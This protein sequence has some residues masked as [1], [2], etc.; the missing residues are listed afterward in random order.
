MFSS[1]DFAPPRLAAV[2]PMR[3]FV[4][5][6]AAV[7]AAGLVWVL[8]AN[9]LLWDALNRAL[10]SPADGRVVV[11]GIDDA[12]LRDYGRI[13]SWPRDLYRQALD[14]LDQAGAS[15]IGVDVLLADPAR[16]DAALA[17]VFSRPNVVLATAPD[18][19]T[20]LRPDW[21][22]P[23]GISALNLSSDG[24]VRSFQAAYPDPGSPDGVA[25]SFARQLAV[26][27]GRNVP[28]D[29]GDRILR[30]SAPHPQRLP[31]V[32]FR[33]V[34]NGT[35][36]YGD[37][38]NRVVVVG[39]TATGAGGPTVRDVGGQ[40]VPG[41]ELQA[42][43][44]SSLLSA[45][46]TTLP[47]W[48]V[49]LAGALAAVAAV[50]AGGL[51][52]FGIALLA[53]ALAVPYWLLNTLL[54]GVTLSLC[55]VLGT[56]LVMLE[57]GLTLRRTGVRDPLT[58]FGNRLAFTRALEGRWQTRHVRPLGLLLVD[59]SGFR[60]VNVAYGYAAGDELLRDLAERILRHK[61]RGDLLFRWGPDEFA[62][63]LDNINSTELAN[64][65]RQVQLSLD[66]MTYRELHLQASVGGAS[67]GPDIVQPTDL[68]EAA[69][70][71]R[72]RI[73]YQREQ[74]RI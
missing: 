41:V 25:P 71:S 74:W 68:I 28:L 10:S 29:S 36:R 44:V 60:K 22:S 66:N 1:P 51:W 53:L 8:P 38:Q 31:V 70:R 33:D 45:P 58:G 61:R 24:V 63:L 9:S 72:Y 4:V 35:I 17:A 40:V 47:L 23:T 7:L 67:T 37:F 39:L 13:S 42:R 52:G 20:T 65:T 32:P 49:M 50:L 55:G 2:R 18:E 6:L 26:A 73:K 48:T 34:V 15:A 21:K 19:P 69:S 46:F 59:L 57:R 62:V 30:Y 5:P 54:P 12:T 16:N 27:A 3:R 43:A 56:G 64:L 11:V 14:T